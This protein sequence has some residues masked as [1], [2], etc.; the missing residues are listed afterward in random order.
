MYFFYSVIRLSSEYWSDIYLLQSLSDSSNDWYGNEQISNEDYSS[1]N[2]KN[3]SAMEL[4]TWTSNAKAF[5]QF[6]IIEKHIK[7]ELFAILR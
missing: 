2:V 6:A 3:G 7:F 5:S 1:T 4:S